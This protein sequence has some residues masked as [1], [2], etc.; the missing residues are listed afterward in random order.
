ME[1]GGTSNPFWKSYV[2]HIRSISASSWSLWM[3]ALKLYLVPMESTARSWRVRTR[4]VDPGRSSK[5]QSTSFCWISSVKGPP[6]WISSDQSISRPPVFQT[7]PP[8]SP[9]IP[10]LISILYPDNS[11]KGDRGL[12]LSAGGGASWA[13]TLAQTKLSDKSK[14]S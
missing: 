7:R 12:D 6:E 10:T 14:A 3:V 13:A 5:R 4:T 9:S 11:W 1:S 2:R 8:N